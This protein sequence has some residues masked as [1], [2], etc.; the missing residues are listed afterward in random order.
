MLINF[1]NSVSKDPLKLSAI[2]DGKVKGYDEL[3][4]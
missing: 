1:V 3:F 2:F 4:V